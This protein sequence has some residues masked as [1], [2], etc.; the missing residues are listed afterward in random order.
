MEILDLFYDELV[1]GK[2]DNIEE[3]SA[4]DGHRSNGFCL[5]NNSSLPWSLDLIKK[6][7][8]KWNYSL[9]SNKG[10]WEK[11]LEP[12]L[13]DEMVKDIIRKE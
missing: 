7:E 4:D 2:N 10:V 12:I 1:W 13:T 9:A 6:Y 11:A 8:N 3:G 5:S